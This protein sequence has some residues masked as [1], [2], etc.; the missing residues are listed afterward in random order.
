MAGLILPPQSPP[1]AVP[2]PADYPQHLERKASRI[3]ELLAERLKHDGLEGGLKVVPSPELLHYRHKVK[4]NLK[5]YAGGEVRYVLFDHPTQEWL[6]W[7]EF[8][9]ASRRIGRLMKELKELLCTDAA[10]Q[11]EAF[12]VELL[13]TTHG[14][15]LASVHYHRR[16]DRSDMA[17]ANRLSRE[18]DA[19]VVLRA[20]R[21]RFVA[22]GQFDYLK[23]HNEI[24]GKCFP[25][26]L[27]ENNFFQANLNLNKEMQRWVVN[28]TG[29]R[30]G[31][32]A[33]DLLEL[34][35][36]NGN[37]TLP[38]AQN[39]RQVLATEMAKPTLESA[40]ACARAAKIRNVQ[41]VRSKAEELDLEALSCR[42][43]NQGP[44]GA[45][46]FSTLLV[47]PPR[48]GLD[49]KTR[50]MAAR[51]EEVIYISCNPLSLVRDLDALQGLKVDAACLFDQFPWTEHAEVAV[52]L[53]RCG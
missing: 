47:D 5:H 43:R 16:L 1:T 26:R 18:L 36:G 7:E 37:F 29:S 48:S 53:R 3:R 51:F 52:H 39:F 40:I 33:R 13:S 20:R 25:Q 15:A 2:D 27:L 4:F 12:E 31:E 45:F 30:D 21:Q 6:E 46:D 34:Y 50:E 42:I 19:S 41:F 11:N 22:R 17:L 49:D 44:V 14:D 10:A 23:Q 9:I 32:P 28:H 8:P 38:S 24:E 35:C